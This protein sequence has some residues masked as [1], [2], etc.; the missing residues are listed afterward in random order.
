MGYTAMLHANLLIISVYYIKF[1]I[2]L[3]QFIIN[4]MAFIYLNSQ[5]SHQV[6]QQRN[7]NNLAGKS[8]NVL[9]NIHTN[10]V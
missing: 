5:I 2:H 9:L 10:V 1:V 4:N 8:S 7:F 6:I 3:L